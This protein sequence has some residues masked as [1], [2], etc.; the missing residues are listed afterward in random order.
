MRL[1]FDVPETKKERCFCFL[2]IF[3]L[4]RQEKFKRENK[5]HRCFGGFLFLSQSIFRYVFVS[6]KCMEQK[7]G[8]VTTIFRVKIYKRSSKNK[9][10]LIKW[11]WNERMITKKENV[12]C[13]LS[14]NWIL[15]Q[16]LLSTV[17]RLQNISIPADIR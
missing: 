15:L 17:L 8:V 6:L 12:E 10:L 1:L 9:Y 4:P 13:L 3:V 11:Y 5:H 14:E 7:T 2:L 16:L